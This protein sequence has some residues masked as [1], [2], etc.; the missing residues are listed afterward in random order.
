M[1]LFQ[2]NKGATTI[3]LSSGD[4]SVQQYAYGDTADGNERVGETLAITVKGATK[5][6]VQENARAIQRLLADGAQESPT[7][8]GE[9]AY[10]EVRL[11]GES[12][13]W[14]S[15]I[16]QGALEGSEQML[17]RWPNV[18]ADMRLFIE[19]KNYFEAAQVEARITTSGQSSYA[20]GGK[21][22]RNL[23]GQNWI[24]I[25]GTEITGGM[26]TPLVI[27]LTNA[28]GSVDW[29]TFYV[30]NHR[31]GDPWTFPYHFTG[32]SAAG[33]ASSS[34]GGAVDH[35]S[36][37]QRWP[38]DANVL[39]QAARRQFNIV[40]ALSSAGQAHARAHLYSKNGSL[41]IPRITTEEVAFNGDGVLHF[42]TLPLLPGEM[43]PLANALAV[44][45]TVRDDNASSWTVANLQLFP[46][47]PG[48]FG[49]FRQQ[50]FSAAGGVAFV[51]DGIDERVYATQGAPCVR[52]GDWP[53]LWPDVN[54]RLLVQ[55]S[56]GTGYSAGAGHDLSAQ[57][58]YRPRRRNI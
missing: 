23:N 29:R 13:L 24:N 49:T 51:I 15:P 27:R 22:L 52:E 9:R 6:E 37:R 57:L 38:L 41:Y 14:R 43:Y 32:S 21:P 40:A 1:H 25:P 10:F 12:G 33:G 16:M 3:N 30:G 46:G 45:L 56:V 5:V 2:L 8:D 42:G 11:D 19:R 58:F 48:E 20:T 34:W 53:Q 47:G 36:Q 4:Y 28:G 54:Q 31:R 44:G 18:F 35:N 50:G 55:F 39:D 7:H 17:R 26:E